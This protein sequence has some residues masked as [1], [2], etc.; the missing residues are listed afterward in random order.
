MWLEAVTEGAGR[1]IAAWGKGEVDAARVR[2][3]K[4]EE[5]RLRKL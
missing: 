2:Q 1:F 5:K 4:R 3:E